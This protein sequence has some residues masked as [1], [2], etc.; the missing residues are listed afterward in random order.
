MRN[1]TKNISEFLVCS[2][3]HESRPVKSTY[4]LAVREKLIKCGKNNFKILTLAEFVT[5]RK[6]NGKQKKKALMKKGNDGF[7]RKKKK[8]VRQTKIKRGCKTCTAN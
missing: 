8:I 6:K 1:D 5:Y 4:T 3:K 7:V 2:K